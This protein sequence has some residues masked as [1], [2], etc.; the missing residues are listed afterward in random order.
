[1]LF[2]EA[3]RQ[4]LSNIVSE[5]LKATAKPDLVILEVDD[6]TAILKVP[7]KWIYKHAMDLPFAFKLPGGQWRF[8]KAGLEDFINNK[9]RP[10]WSEADL[11]KMNEELTKKGVR[12]NGVKG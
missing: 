1:M 6:V 2:N 9:T 12:T 5:Q 10:I 3:V 4:E 8:V 7:K 11:K